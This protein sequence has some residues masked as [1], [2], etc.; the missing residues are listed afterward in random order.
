MDVR[1]PNLELTQETRAILG[2]L[3]RGTKEL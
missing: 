2:E 1:Q 3:E